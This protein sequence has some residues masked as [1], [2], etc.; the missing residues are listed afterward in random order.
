M[1]RGAFMTFVNGFLVV[2]LSLFGIALLFLLEHL[3]KDN[4]VIESLMVFGSLLVI[5][6]WIISILTQVNQ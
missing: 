4:K 5:L 2:A 1:F 6:A 3:T